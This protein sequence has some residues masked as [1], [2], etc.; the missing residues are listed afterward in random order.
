[1]IIL[2]L[3]VST[4][5]IGI[6]VLQKTAASVNLIHAEGM[7]LSK[8]KGL[9]PKAVLFKQ[10]LED[11]KELLGKSGH[12]VSRIIVEEPLQAFRSRMSSAGTIA[13]LNRFNGMIS[14]I[15]AQAFDLPAEMASVVS[16]RKQINLK[17]EKKS[18][19]N[20]KEQ[21]LDWVMQNYVM[22]DYDWPTKILKS[23]PNKGQQ[24]FEAH[25]FDIA[26]AF[27]V[28]YWAATVS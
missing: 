27:V 21:V 26:D 22:L 18:E 19:K 11:L 20:T 24:R 16:V 12:N 17:L 7:P 5:N 13:T 15:A 8:T 2:G 1:M 4:S 25:C 28:A 9:I 14:Y 3:D 23:G 10:R 6:C